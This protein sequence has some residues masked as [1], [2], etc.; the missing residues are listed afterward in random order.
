MKSDFFKECVHLLIHW[1]WLMWIFLSIFLTIF[2]G[3]N[4]YIVDLF[5][6]FVLI[7]FKHEND[8]QKYWIISF[9]VTYTL[10][11]YLNG[12]SHSNFESLSYLIGPLAFY[13]WGKE[14]MKRTLSPEEVCTFFLLI[15]ICSSVE[16]V[17][18]NMQDVYTS[19]LVNS[20][21]FIEGFELAATMQG[22]VASIGL[23]GI[24]YPV[25]NK[26]IL[27]LKS[28]LFIFVF[29]LNLFVV[30]HLLNRTGI[31]VAA[32]VMMLVSLYSYKNRKVGIF[33]VLFIFGLIFLALYQAGFLSSE[34]I[35]LYAERNEYNTSNVGGRSDRWLFALK[36]IFRYPFGWYTIHG[37]GFAHNMWLDIARSTG[38]IPFLLFLI[39]TI[40]NIKVLLRLLKNNK[41][42]VVF[43]LGTNVCLLLSSFVEPVMEAR[44]TYLYLIFMVW[45]IQNQY[46][47]SLKSNDC[48]NDITSVH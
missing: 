43:L 31:V 13:L 3:Y 12:I 27:N 33:S 41:P 39:I 38:F 24:S 35:D 19:G 46:Y 36:S 22:L 26:K 5:C 34:I 18:V 15:M 48:I 47:K 29:V 40:K 28:L 20:D 4:V 10:I 21:R 37:I 1:K 2:S 42:F 25:S 6:F 14:V 30:L 7:L 11:I 17:T 23:S 9:S 16:L 44:S 32:V 45:G 8:K